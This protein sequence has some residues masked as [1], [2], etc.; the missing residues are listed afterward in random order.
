M[1]KLIC[2]LPNGPF[3]KVLKRLRLYY[4]PLQYLRELSQGSTESVD[5]RSKEFSELLDD[6]SINGVSKKTGTGRLAS[7]DRWV[8]SILT[9]P[10]ST[11]L[12]MLDVGG[13]DGSTT[14]D[15]M[16]YFRDSLGVKVKATILDMQL[17]L[18]C[19]HRGGLRYYV[20]HE[21]N[22][23]LM[24]IGVFG[25]LFEEITTKEG[26]VFNPVLRVTKKALQRFSFEKY[27]QNCGDL[28]LENPIARRSPDIAW[29][30]QDLF[31]FDPELVGA[32][33]FVRCCNVL[34]YSYFSERQICDAV[35]L[36]ALYLKPGGLLVVSRT[37]DHS[38][39]LLHDASL[40]M[41]MGAGLQHVSDLNGGSEI[42]RLVPLIQR[43]K[44]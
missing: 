36:L 39:S 31:R 24:Q 14:F 30:E 32:F 6:V 29:L 22:P 21:K 40:W 41:K 5:A 28:Y 13:S 9:E 17:R 38:S 19:Y 43:G 34:N 4:P 23:L 7:I 27:L 15:T 35:E 18:H 12:Q 44:Q 8:A 42:K 25:I 2:R 10:L 16:S 1:F 11:P 33:D 3:K 37:I 20:T 26:F